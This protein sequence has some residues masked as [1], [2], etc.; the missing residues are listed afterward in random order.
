M[1]KDQDARVGVL[2]SR[3]RKLMGADSMLLN[4]KEDG[5]H[6]LFT[7]TVVDRATLDHVVTAIG[8]ESGVTRVQLE[9]TMDMSFGR[10][11]FVIYLYLKR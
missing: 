1:Q 8:K 3:A 2:R 6:V 5:D 4:F 9:S 10:V 7:G 11:R